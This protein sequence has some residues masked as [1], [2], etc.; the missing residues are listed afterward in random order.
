MAGNVRLADY[1][2]PPPEKFNDEQSV[3]MLVQS[4]D[5]DEKNNAIQA[6]IEKKDLRRGYVANFSEDA[7]YLVDGGAFIDTQPNFKFYTGMTLLDFDGG[8]KLAKDMNMPVRALVMGPSGQMYIRNETD[9]KPIVEYHKKLFEKTN[10][11]HRG[12][13]G[14]PGGMGPEGGGPRPGPRRPR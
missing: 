7:E 9:D 14:G 1:K 5:V 3:T 13:E 2:F 10:P 11:N 12:P 8:A 6:A 4:F